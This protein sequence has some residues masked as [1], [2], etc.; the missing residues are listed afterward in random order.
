MSPN[1][2]SIKDFEE[3]RKILRGFRPHSGL[4][5]I[6]RG[7]SDI[8]W[9]LLPKA[10]RKE[11]A[12]DGIRDLGR[13]NEWKMNS[14]AYID[15]PQNEWEVLAIAQHFGLATRLL[16]W[17]LNPL[18][19]LFFAA[20]KDFDRSG[21]VYF[22]SPDKYLDDKIA[23]ISK[24]STDSDLEKDLCVAYLPRAIDHRII[25][26]KGVF[27]YHQNPTIPMKVKSWRL[28]TK[29]P[30]LFCVDIPSTQKKEI[31]LELDDYGINRSFLFP[32]LAGLSEYINT[33]TKFFM[34]NKS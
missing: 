12:L 9:D 26:Q 8:E 3:Y 5:W 16:D 22:F 7:Q 28:E 10:G 6:Y 21:S 1:H 25:N 34:E 31:L 13:F 24:I 4:G 23:N 2:V 17:S 29:F 32:D 14:I 18:V 15:I 27:T 19:A 11:Y 20:E 30:N 33:K